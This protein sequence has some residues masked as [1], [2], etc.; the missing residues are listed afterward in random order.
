MSSITLLILG[1]LATWRISR[2]LNYESG[3]RNIFDRL[4]AFLAHNQKKSGGMFD[5][6]SCMSCLSVY[7]GGIISF[8]INISCSGINVGDFFLWSLALSAVSM[9]FE[10]I[11]TS[12]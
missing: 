5:M 1:G 7:V 9:I 4:R 3:P 11:A 6:I 8:I 10:K 12:L 2:M